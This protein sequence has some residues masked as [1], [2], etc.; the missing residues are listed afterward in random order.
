[1][2][3]VIGWQEYTIRKTIDIFYQGHNQFKLGVSL[4]LG[5]SKPVWLSPFMEISTSVN[6]VMIQTNY[7]Y[8]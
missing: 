6:N 3:Q 4:I 2:D 7:H 1:M 8:R 5:L